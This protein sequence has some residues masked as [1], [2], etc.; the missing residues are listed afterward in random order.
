MESKADSILSPSSP[1]CENIVNPP[2]STLLPTPVP[3][4]KRRSKHCVRIQFNL[5]EA[6]QILV[7]MI[8]HSEE[9]WLLSGLESFT[10]VDDGEEEE[11]E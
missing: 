6:E 1:P 11:Q 10:K 3:P 5:L 2:T 7:N 9:E 8:P 4:P